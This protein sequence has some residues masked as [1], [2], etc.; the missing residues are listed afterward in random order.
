MEPLKGEDIAEVVLFV[1]TRPSHVNISDMIVFPTAQA[2]ATIVA[3][4][5]D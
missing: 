4:N 2:S 5:D 3:R 1:L